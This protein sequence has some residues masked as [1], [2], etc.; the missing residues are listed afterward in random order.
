MS[1]LQ[2]SLVWVISI[3]YIAL[4][5]SMIGLMPFSIYLYMQDRNNRKKV[6]ADINRKLD[7]DIIVDINLL[8]QISR[9]RGVTEGFAAQCIR[10]LLAE[11]NDMGRINILKGLA[12]E[13][14][15]VEP[16]AD[17]PGEAKASLTKLRGMLLNSPSLDTSVLEPI[18]TNLNAY[19][20]LRSNAYR[21]KNA[22]RFFDGFSLFI[23]V[24]GAYFALTS[25][26]LQDYKL[27]IKNA[28]SEAIVQTPKSD[29][30]K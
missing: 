28:V 27:I 7:A 11:S 3:T 14:D 10:R 30:E 4:V 24:L 23:G 5:I 15:K 22:R 8:R 1:L 12:D 6:E 29:S 18:V 20:E 21:N 17:L 16:Y 19:V 26:S 13:F 2:G 9:A 25:P